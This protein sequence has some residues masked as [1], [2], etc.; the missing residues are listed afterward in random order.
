VNVQSIAMRI[1]QPPRELS[2]SEH[3]MIG[4]ANAK[5]VCLQLLAECIDV[6]SVRPFVE[7]NPK[8]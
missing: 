1:D 5:T 8:L 4:M 2:D 3:G 7:W 6:F